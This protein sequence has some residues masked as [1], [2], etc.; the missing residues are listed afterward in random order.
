MHPTGDV[1]SQQEKEA[2]DNDAE[3]E[4]EDEAEEVGA[5]VAAELPGCT[6]PHHSTLF[7]CVGC[8]CVRLCVCVCARAREREIAWRGAQTRGG[9]PSRG[10][11][12]IWCKT[13]FRRIQKE[14]IR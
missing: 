7:V 6:L 5:A 3:D 4:A 14:G 9:R 13:D 10:E 8:A 12:E 2:D 1:R 11:T